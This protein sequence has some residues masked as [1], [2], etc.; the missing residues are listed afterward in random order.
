MGVTTWTLGATGIVYELLIALEI[1]QG[2]LYAVGAF[3]E[4][5]REVLGLCLCLCP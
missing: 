5:P 2:E 1:P 3:L 4:L